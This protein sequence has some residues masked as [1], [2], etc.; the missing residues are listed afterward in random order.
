MRKGTD[1]TLLSWGWRSGGMADES[2]LGETWRSAER[3]IDEVGYAL[4]RLNAKLERA[5]MLVERLGRN[6]IDVP[7]LLAEMHRE[8]EEPST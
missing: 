2:G 5:I 6:G 1:P 8:R 7:E 4:D 3:S